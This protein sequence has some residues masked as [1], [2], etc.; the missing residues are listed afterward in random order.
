MRRYGVSLLFFALT[1]LGALETHAQPEPADAVLAEERGEF[2]LAWGAAQKGDIRALAP[3]LDSLKD[4]PLYPYLRYAYLD[5]TLD[6][7]P[8][9][10]VE[11]FLVENQDLPLD[12]VLRDHWLLSLDK[13]QEWAKILAYY[14]DETSPALRCA[15]VSAHYLKSDE[16]DHDAWTGAAKQLWL[17]P[18]SPPE[19]C[20]ALFD[21]LEAHK[22]VTADMRRRRVQFALQAKDTARVMALLPTLEPGDRAW[23]LAWVAM[24]Q[25]PAHALEDIQVPQDPPYLEMLLAGVRLVARSEPLKAEHLWSQLS[26]RY[27]FPHDDARDMRTLLALQQA[28]HLLPGARATLKRLHEAVDPQVPEWRLRLAIRD[29]DWREVLHDIEGLGSGADLPEWRYW[30]ARALE[31]LGRRSDARWVYS[32]LAKAAD[33]YG[34][35][36]ADRLGAPYKIVQH[37]SEPDENVIRQLGARPGMVRARELVYAGLYPQAE[38]EW[39]FASRDLSLAARCQAA[40]LAERWGWHGRVIPSL[41]SGG[42][43]QDLSLIY[44]LAFTDTLGPTAE[45]LNLDLSWVYGLIRTESVFRPNAVSPVGAVGLM[46]LMPATGRDVASRLGLVVDQ[47][48]A[49]LDPE[50]N[51]A[52]GSMYLHEVLQH[53]SGSETLATAAYDAGTVKVEDWLPEKGSLPMDVWIDTIPYTETRNYVHRVMGHTVM[54]DWRLNGTPKRLMQRI[55]EGVDGGGLLATATLG[56]GAS[57]QSNP[58]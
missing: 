58:H 6:D 51:L 13:R 25:D 29:Q 10:V 41:A 47:K 21:Y 22:L 33:Y 48:G 1:L 7:A 49:L 37:A 27:R 35:L 23:A 38:S 43:W 12:D 17:S 28:W 31:G 30:K 54:F 4:Y 34:F 19:Y 11:Q 32:T 42:C 57:V 2:K 8:D 53:F 44:P 18:A 24:D 45:R 15:A 39:D 16:P 52:V 5:A 46:Q 20:A 3:Y 14:R 26:N 40:L 55:G 56:L 9:G 50:M 36:A